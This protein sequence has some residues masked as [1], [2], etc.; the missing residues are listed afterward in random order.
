MTVT[1]L[2]RD[3]DC[4]L[5]NR[6]PDGPAPWFLDPGGRSKTAKVRLFFTF[7]GIYILS[8]T[9]NS[10]LKTLPLLP[11]IREPLEPTPVLELL[12]LINNFK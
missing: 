6:E 7:P 4:S 12:L 3:Q 2:V 9:V 5:K 11:G 8:L 10:V 1:P